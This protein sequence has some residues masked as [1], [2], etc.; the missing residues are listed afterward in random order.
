MKKDITRAI[1]DATVDRGL[2][3][4]NED[5]RRSIRKLADLG[6][7]F[8]NGRFMQDLYAIFQDL[9]RNDDSPY[10]TAIEHLLQNTDRKALK[11]FGINMGYNGF[12]KGGKKI[13]NFYTKKGLKVPWAI[14]IRLDPLS[15][16]SITPHDLISLIAEGKKL[17]IFS[18]IITLENSL[19]YLEDL[20]KV[21]MTY[22]DCAFMLNMPDKEMDASISPFVKECRNVLYFLPVFDD[23]IGQ[24]VS[25]LK[26]EKAWYGLYAHYDENN[27]ENIISTES[28]WEYLLQDA[29]FLITIAKDG[30]DQ[31]VIDSTTQKI[32]QTRLEPVVPLFIFDLYGD[33]AQIQ[34][35][36]SGQIFFFEILSDGT[37]HTSNGIFKQ[38]EGL[39]DLEKAFAECL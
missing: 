12:T 7:Q 8:N 37:L 21:F 33:A 29:A 10:Y 14:I 17:G 39:P 23:S 5:P 1:M 25:I 27:A 4:I 26:R 2:K 6:K 28:T 32:K 11:D 3:E 9:L 24:N 18:Y 13:R 34:K 22:D 20:L 38:K 30:T 36:I 35:L 16:N 31:S 19:D 15:R